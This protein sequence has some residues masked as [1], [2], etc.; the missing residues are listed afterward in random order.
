MYKLIIGILCFTTIS[1][2]FAGELASRK[3]SE[4]TVIIAET[5]RY[6]QAPQEWD[7]H[8]QYT[9]MNTIQKIQDARLEILNENFDNRQLVNNL[10]RNSDRLTN[11][12]SE[13]NRYLSDRKEWNGSA[14]YKFS[15]ILTDLEILKSFNKE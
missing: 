13:L 12:I 1:S 7:D 11:E 15:R 4:V 2:T 5:N 14:K 6:V 3:L 9:L 8:A 10:I